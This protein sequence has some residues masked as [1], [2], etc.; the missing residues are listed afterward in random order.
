MIKRLFWEKRIYDSWKQAPIAWLAGVRRSGKTTLAQ[1][2]GSSNDI[3]YVNCD[4]PITEDRVRDPQLFFKNCEK[5]IVVFDE[6]HQLSDP[7][8]LLKIGADLFPHL[9]ILATGSS[10]LAASRKFRDT[11]TGRKRVIHLLPV[12]WTE[13]EAFSCKDILRRFFQGGLPPALLAGSKST[14]FYREWL[15]SFFARD[16]Q[17][18]FPIRDVEKFNMLFEYLLRQ[19]GGQFETSKVA[20]ELKISR[21]TV[22]SHLKALEITQAVTRIRPFFGRGLK[23]IVKMPKIYGFDTGFI[24][25]VRGWDPLRPQDSGILWEH[26]VL[27]YLQ[28]SFPD[29]TINYW[30]D[31][32]GREIDFVLAQKR[33]QIDTV[34]CKWNSLD[35]DPAALKVFR[36]YYPK[37]NNYLVCPLMDKP[38]VKRYGSLIVT[39]CAPQEIK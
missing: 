13:L 8:R 6:I 12:L 34:E 31:K 29:Q 22:E 26:L 21:V 25:F 35:F 38:Y 16:V 27:E 33:D 14:S 19:S 36:S 18:L 11:L 3:I 37:G 15:D 30:R 39:I 1:S 17:K 7:S 28:A 2:L 4:L 20:A 32:E 23:E 5:S 10:T 24:T 9:K